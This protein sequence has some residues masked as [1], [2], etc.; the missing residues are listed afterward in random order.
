MSAEIIDVEDDPPIATEAWVELPVGRLS[1][2]VQGEGQE[3]GGSGPARLGA[4]RAAPLR[5]PEDRGVGNCS[6]AL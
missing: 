1:D 3:R 2:L 6:W 4:T 5:W